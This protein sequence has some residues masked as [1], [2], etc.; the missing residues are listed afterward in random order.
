M[1]CRLLVLGAGLS[2]VSERRTDNSSLLDMRLDRVGLECFVSKKM[3][4]TILTRSKIKKL[5]VA[6]EARV[7]E[8]PVVDQILTTTFEIVVNSSG[9][10]I[11]SVL[12][13]VMGEMIDHEPEVAV[14]PSLQVYYYCTPPPTLFFHSGLSSWYS[15]GS[16]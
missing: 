9:S 5:Y 6:D 2:V 11:C 10:V 7:K 16:T 15:L 3:R 12:K 1:Q 4:K 8:T 14:E 13:T